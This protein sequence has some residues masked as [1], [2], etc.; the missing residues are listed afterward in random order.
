M[1]PNELVNAWIKYH[2]KNYINYCFE[3]KEPRWH[4][5]QFFLYS[6]KLLGRLNND[7]RWT[8]YL[9]KYSE[10]FRRD[11]ANDYYGY[12]DPSD[13]NSE[14]AMKNSLEWANIFELNNIVG[15]PY[16]ESAKEKMLKRSE[17]F[18]SNALQSLPNFHHDIL[19]CSAIEFM[20][21]YYGLCSP[22]TFDFIY[23]SKEHGKEE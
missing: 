6:Y 23:P 18:L 2:N 3:Y 11:P 5:K 22:E 4:T 17:R 12:R 13:Q 15:F 9:S 1:Q 19:I 20:P 16:N 14:K 7:N 8:D 10:I 21:G